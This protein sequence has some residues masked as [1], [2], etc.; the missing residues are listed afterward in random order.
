MKTFKTLNNL[1]DFFN[2]NKKIAFKDAFIVFKNGHGQL[3]GQT[4]GLDAHR[5]VQDKAGRWFL[6]IGDNV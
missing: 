6:D 4:R 1:V 3:C 2:K 5:I